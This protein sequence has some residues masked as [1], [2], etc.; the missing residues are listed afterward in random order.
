MTRGEN[1]IAGTNGDIIGGESQKMQEVRTQILIE[2]H[3]P[4]T[5]QRKTLP[6]LQ[7][8]AVSK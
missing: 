8:Y 5:I 1:K 6:Y 7:Q 3:N 4:K 2:K